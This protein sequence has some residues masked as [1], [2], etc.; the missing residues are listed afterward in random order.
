MVYDGYL[1][2]GGNE[3]VNSPR[4]EGITRTFDCYVP[5]LVGESCPFLQDAIGDSPYSYAN[6]ATAPWYDPSQPELSS[7]VLGVYG[8]GFSGVKDSTRQVQLTE[9]LDDGGVVGSM[10]KG[11]RQVRT[12]I[13]ILAIGDDAMEY[14]RTWL[15]AALDPG[16]CGQHAEE[17][18]TTDVEYLATC[19]PERGTVTYL[20]DWTLQRTNLLTN[21]SGEAAGAV[22]PVR[23]NGARNPRQI[24]TGYVGEAGLRYT[25]QWARSF[26]TGLAGH[27][28]GITT[29]A[30]ATCTAATSG[31]GFGFD[32]YGNPDSAS[33]GNTGTWLD[34]PTAV[35]GG[36][37]TVSAWVR[38][39]VAQNV[40]LGIRFFNA[41]TSTWTS[42]QLNTVAA[43]TAG[44]WTL[45]TNTQT[46]P[47]STTNFIV[48]T[49]FATVSSSFAVGDY[50]E[51]T[52]LMIGSG[53]YFDGGTQPVL[54]TNWIRNANFEVDASLWTTTNAATQSRSTAQSHSGSASLQVVTAGSTSGEGVY[55]S[56]YTVPG[57]VTG[58]PYA[59]GIWVLAPVG[60]AMEALANTVGTGGSVPVV[61][62]TGTGAWQYVSMPNNTA[63]SG[64]APYILVR[65]RGT[66]QAITFY[67]DDAMLEVG[68]SVAGSYFD[69]TVVPRG[70]AVGWQGTANASAT[71]LWDADFSTRW[72]G[73][74]NSSV[75]ELTGI[76]APS[77]T[78]AGA[79]ALP[80]IRSSRFATD[81]SYSF[82]SVGGVVP[83]VGAY[84]EFSG[85]SANATYTNIITA[86]SESAM[87]GTANIRQLTARCYGSATPLINGPSAGSAAS[88]TTLRQTFTVP[89][90]ASTATMR[91]YLTNAAAGT[92]I[93]D[94][95]WDLAALIPGSYSGP[96]FTGRTTPTDPAMERYAWTGAA[97]ASTS[98]Y[99][100]RQWLT[101]PETDDE[102]AV[103]VDPLRRYL[104]GVAAT[105]GPNTIDEFHR[106]LAT[107]ETIVGQVVEFTLT[108]SRPW[109]YGVTKPVQLPSTTPFVIE[110]VRYNLVKF[111]S[112]QLTSDTPVLIGRNYSLNPSVE[113][114][115]TGWSFGQSGAI[116]AA[117][118]AGTR[119]TELAA[120]GT[121]SYKATF[122]STTTGTGTMSVLQTVALPAPAPLPAVTRF[123]INMWAAALAT[124]GTPTLSTI[125]F[126]VDWLNSSNTVLRTDA[127]GTQPASGGSVTLSNI[128]PPTGATQAR[129]SATVTVSSIANGNVVN[130]FADALAVTV[131]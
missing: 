88:T 59:A 124:T 69:T 34:A 75:S 53:P 47:A 14:A 68:V 92:I 89:A 100:I 99:E 55:S 78:L 119:S 113:T 61:Q 96:A 31:T 90:D 44:A 77:V 94:T 30:R 111:P 72:Q 128:L 43:A 42:A 112:M 107:G 35:A 104:H 60:A 36:S 38:S 91:I 105:G 114:N 86:Y 120:V 97:D 108:A 117:Q 51:H 110:D 45:L 126:S 73:T 121:A 103:V 23:Q 19:P 62:F 27:P 22:V 50:F 123:S 26:Q 82:R 56:T 37:Y 76:S 118:M 106:K 122:T 101:R 10:R 130:L 18:G 9:G 102:Y 131:P 20:S 116:T 109:V 79:G 54:R 81:G 39:S 40:R 58:T 1:R 46:A 52:G 33:P 95:W 127:L 12:R 65:T 32:W 63:N 57:V 24:S 48:Q 8:L 49:T 74:A 5:W 2:M 129:V 85:M 6:I 15:E 98:T 71:N 28:L 115:T 83:A 41:S 7:R 21:P 66:A 84:F 87:P 29:S 93:P 13:G 3:I 67:L 25:S 125:A 16:A 17:C 64:A 80:V 70:Y 4:A 11:V